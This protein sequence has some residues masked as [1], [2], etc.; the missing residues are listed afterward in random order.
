MAL[1]SGAGTS[2]TLTPRPRAHVS[3]FPPRCFLFAGAAGGR[4]P[5]RRA[6]DI[7]PRPPSSTR[8]V[9]VLAYWGLGATI[10]RAVCLDA[11]TDARVATVC[12]PRGKR[13]DGTF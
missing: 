4:Y 11:V 5:G 9:G 2:V 3:M 6:V 10:H 8:G 7:P 13:L 12:A 1:W